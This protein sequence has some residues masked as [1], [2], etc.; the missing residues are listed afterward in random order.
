VGVG[1]VVG[2]TDGGTA[3]VAD[4]AAADGAAED[5]GVG[6]EVGSGGVGQFTLAMLNGVSEGEALAG[7]PVA[8]G[9]GVDTGVDVALGVGVAT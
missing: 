3:A 7:E 1:P 4:G 9:V 8:L 2:A 5:D 6:T